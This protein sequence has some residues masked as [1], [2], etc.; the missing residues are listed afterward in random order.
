MG[1][2]PSDFMTTPNSLVVID[3]LPSLSNSENASLYSE[4]KKIKV[5]I[6]WIS[7]CTCYFA[8]G[9]QRIA[10]LS[11]LQNFCTSTAE[12]K[13]QICVI[14]SLMELLLLSVV[15]CSIPLHQ[16]II[17]QLLCHALEKCLHMVEQGR[18]QDFAKGGADVR[19]EMPTS[20][21]S[22]SGV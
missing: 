2:W 10:E 12:F 11:E 9:E 16:N 14:L 15:V 21:Q 1:F 19:H 20:L 3:P 22:G 5:N 13:S 8:D 7:I 6:C 18:R 4:E 17:D